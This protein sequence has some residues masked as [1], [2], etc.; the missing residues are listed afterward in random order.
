MARLAREKPLS[1]LN[2][3]LQ[4]IEESHPYGY[5]GI[6][7][8]DPHGDFINDLLERIPDERVGDV[9]LF[10]PTNA[11]HPYGL[12]LFDC[13]KDDPSERDRVVS[14]VIDTLY[15]LFSPSSRPRMEDLLRHAIHSLLL[16]PEPTTLLDLMLLLV[17]QEHRYD[18]TKEAKAL[19]PI[20]RAY[21][22]D[23]FP[24]GDE[25]K[26][27]TRDQRDMVS[28]SL[29]KVGRFLV[30]PILRNIICQEHSTVNFQPGIDKGRLY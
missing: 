12:N 14:T 16:H 22:R 19:D 18:L 10:D 26:G 1:F 7:M 11:A 20:L 23:Q 30:N 2:M 6:C 28:S 8:L 29:N 3:I 15:K 9:I 13:N 21:W 5:D 4:D 27:M 24:E 17:S 25:W